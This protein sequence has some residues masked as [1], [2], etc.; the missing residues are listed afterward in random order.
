MNDGGADSSARAE[1]VACE[2]CG[3]S[4]E[5]VHRDAIGAYDD[6]AAAE[7]AVVCFACEGTGMDCVDMPM[8]DTAKTKGDLI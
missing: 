1:W 5:I 6:P 8:M 2:A 7:Y 4:G 3:G